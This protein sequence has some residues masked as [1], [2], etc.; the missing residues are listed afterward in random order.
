MEKLPKSTIVCSDL[1]EL[2]KSNKVLADL[3][4][5]PKSLKLSALYQDDFEILIYQYSE[6]FLDPDLHPPRLANPV[7]HRFEMLDSPIPII[8]TIPFIP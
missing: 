6:W 4:K 7:F 2:L 3:E 1:E 5:L 8:P